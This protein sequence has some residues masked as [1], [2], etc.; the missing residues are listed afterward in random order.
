MFSNFASLSFSCALAPLSP[1]LRRN[2]K[3]W[4]PQAPESWPSRARW[5]S[6]L[7]CLPRRALVCA[8]PALRTATTVCSH[9]V[10]S[11]VVVLVL[12]RRCARLATR[13]APTTA[14]RRATACSAAP[15]VACLA[16]VVSTEPS[17]LPATSTAFPHSPARERSRWMRGAHR[18][19]RAGVHQHRIIESTEH[20][21]ILIG[22][23]S[24]GHSSAIT[25]NISSN[26][27]LDA[28]GGGVDVHA[29]YDGRVHVLAQ[30]AA[31]FAKGALQR[32]VTVVIVLMVFR[33]REGG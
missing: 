27:A 8:R 15:P 7:S 25:S 5:R 17:V 11:R 16:P 13:P 2:S 1:P 3:Q 22:S 24:L 30:Q 32:G 19:V 12:T 23:T 26:G 10:P 4:S 21:Y 6:W 14:A 9:A 28:V 20:F 33:V 29:A 18:S 31:R